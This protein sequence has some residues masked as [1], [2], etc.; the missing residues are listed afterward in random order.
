MASLRALAFA[1]SVLSVAMIPSAAMAIQEPRDD[2]HYT[3]VGF[4]DIH[5]CNWPG[6]GIFYLALFS[7]EHFADIKKIEIYYPDD[8]KLG[9]LDI[10][11]Y[12]ILPA[13]NTQ[14]EKR[15]FMT[16]FAMRPGAP[17]GWFSATITRHDGSRYRARDLVMNA[18]IGRASRQN[19]PPASEA[20]PAPS[21]LSWAPID[22]ATRYK[23][24]IKDAFLEQ[25]IFESDLLDVPALKVPDGLL[26]KGGAYLWQVHASDVDGHVELGDFNAG[27]LSEFIA[28]SV[29]E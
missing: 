10:A 9:D 29:E 18:P 12:R 11:R 13:K 2:Q 27:S 8:Q 28:F 22:G 23:V 26:E 6:R 16:N 14:R 25:I 20:I 19:P 21:E 24:F 15:V 4:F 17:E 7:T 5:L 3:D 1:L